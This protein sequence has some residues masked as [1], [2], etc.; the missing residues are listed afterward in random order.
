MLRTLHIPTKA[1]AHEVGHRLVD[2]VALAQESLDPLEHRHR[3]I[4]RFGV[5]VDGTRHR[6]PP[7]VLCVLHDF[8]APLPQR[9]QELI[10]RH[11]LGRRHVVALVVA[12]TFFDEILAQAA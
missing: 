12:G 11:V 7:E 2:G 5:I 10:E 8:Y 9:H 6:P 1:H 3:L 4:G